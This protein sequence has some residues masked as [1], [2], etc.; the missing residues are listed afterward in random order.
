MSISIHD[1]VSSTKPKFHQRRLKFLGKD[2]NFRHL[3]LFRSEFVITPEFV[4]QATQ[5]IVRVFPIFIGV[6]AQSFK[7]LVE[8]F[9][10]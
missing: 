8:W 4:V 5:N 10:K 1:S 9:R 2:T 7:V 6:N 3:S